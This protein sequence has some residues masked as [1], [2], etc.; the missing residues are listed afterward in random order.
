[1]NLDA[2]FPD[3]DFVAPIASS[4]HV[5]RTCHEDGTHHYS[6]LKHL[7]KSGKQYIHACNTPFEPNRAMLIGTAVHVLTLGPRPGK[8]VLCF[9]GK[10]RKG[11]D[12][13]L[14]KAAHPKADILT[15][16]EWDEA[17]EI[18]NAVL[19]DPIA[20]ERLAGARFEV[21]L[22]WEE[23]GIKFST[24]GIDILRGDELTDLKTTGTVEPDVWK[25]HASRMLY[26]C[27]LAFYRRGARANGI[28]IKRLFLLG[29]ETKGPFEVVELEMSERHIELAEKS[30]ALWIEK[31]RV[32]RESN[33]WP[34][35]SQSTIA[36]D[37][38][39]WAD[40]DEEEEEAA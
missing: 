27:Q 26:D 17:E 33:Q 9:P 37:A 39:S 13:K 22:Q 40:P 25:R 28:P 24:D 23:D 7:A 4:A 11:G 36:W 1:M 12:Y 38:P 6:L 15:R 32:Y 20:R 3:D 34:G 2:P 30:I 21:P 8:S 14:F 29:V 31:L 16:T 35:Y 18:A 19:N 10:D 5:P